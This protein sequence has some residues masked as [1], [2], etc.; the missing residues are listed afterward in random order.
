MVEV[1][2]N[3]RGAKHI[4]FPDQSFCIDLNVYEF[5]T[6]L[7]FARERFSGRLTDVHL[8]AGPA[9]VAPGRVR[10]GVG[11]SRVVANRAAGEGGRTGVGGWM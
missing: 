9:Q 7:A 10:D 6:V 5:R 1:A 2:I 11:W 4:R 3:E 8:A